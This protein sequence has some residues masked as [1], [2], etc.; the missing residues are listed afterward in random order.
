VRWVLRF[1]FALSLRLDNFARL[2]FQSWTL[3]LSLNHVLPP[4]LLPFFLSTNLILDMS[5]TIC[6]D[7]VFEEQV[8]RVFRLWESTLGEL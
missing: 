8:S 3:A 1:S 2:V 6:A 5:V 7:G 4:P